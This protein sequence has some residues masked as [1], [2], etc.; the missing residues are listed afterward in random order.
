MTLVYWGYPL[1][2]IQKTMEKST[3]FNSFLYV[4]QAGHVSGDLQGSILDW[5]LKT[6]EL[7]S[8]IAAGVTMHLWQVNVRIWTPRGD[9]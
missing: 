6:R 7:S 3:I 2:N 1:V 5:P 8:K 9:I 4:Y